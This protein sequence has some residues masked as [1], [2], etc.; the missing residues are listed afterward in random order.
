MSDGTP[1]I[2]IGKPGGF[3]FYYIVAGNLLGPCQGLWLALPL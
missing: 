1:R 2:E 3:W